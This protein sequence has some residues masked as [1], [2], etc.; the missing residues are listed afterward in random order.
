MKITVCRHII[1]TVT[2][3][4]MALCVYRVLQYGR[5]VPYFGRHFVH[6]ALIC[7]TRQVKEAEYASIFC[8]LFLF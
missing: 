6:N 1:I 8:F 4:G 2:A 3:L 5:Y 7:S